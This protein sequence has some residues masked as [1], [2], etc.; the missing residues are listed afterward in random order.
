MLGRA[1]FSDFRFFCICASLFLYGVFGSP[2]PDDPGVFEVLIGVL[3]IFASLSGRFVYRLGHILGVQVA[4]PDKYYCYGGESSLW[5]NWHLW[6]YGFLVYCFTV[7]LLMA[8]LYGSEAHYIWRDL[9]AVS[10]I[11]Y[12]VI[13][14]NIVLKAERNE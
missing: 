3:L 9:F 13:I 14:R 6:A 10:L 12:S 1:D 11:F 8:A 5:Q 2:T 4:T 7:P